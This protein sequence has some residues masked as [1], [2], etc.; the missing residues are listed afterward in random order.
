[1]Y[2]WLWSVQEIHV[3]LRRYRARVAQNA[4]K[5]V[6]KSKMIAVVRDG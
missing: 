6:K 2:R 3:D 1:M 4:L 5:H